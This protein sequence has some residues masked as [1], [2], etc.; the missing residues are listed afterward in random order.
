MSAKKK[1][2]RVNRK[3]PCKNLFRGTIISRAKDAYKK[4]GGNLRTRFRA[5]IVAAKKAVKHAGGPRN[6][7]IPRVIPVRKTGGF[8][9]FLIPI[10]AGLSAVGSL[11]GGIS[12]ITKAVNDA[13]NATVKLDEAKRHNKIMESIGLGKQGSGLFLKPY[14]KGLGLYIKPKNY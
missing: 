14:R 9:P 10:L 12:S 6:I 1:S 13:K 5:A 7:F 8:I 11:A 2:F 4:E 3:Q